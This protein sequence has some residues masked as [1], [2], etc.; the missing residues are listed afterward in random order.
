MTSF[1]FKLYKHSS[2]LIKTY[3]YKI[4]SIYC[5]QNNPTLSCPH[6]YY[7]KHSPTYNPTPN[8][9]KI[10]HLKSNQNRNIKEESQKSHP[11]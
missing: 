4:L 11:T 7:F 1:Q 5:F 2:L 3:N 8:P 10:I 6:D 9:L